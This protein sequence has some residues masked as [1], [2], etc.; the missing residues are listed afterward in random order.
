MKS[1]FPCTPLIQD[2]VTLFF[3][4]SSR[5]RLDREEVGEEEEVGREAEK[6]EH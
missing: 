6:E 2:D 3:Y 5:I 4:T 1:P